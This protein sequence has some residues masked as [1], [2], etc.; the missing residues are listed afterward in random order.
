MKTI[1]ELFETPKDSPQYEANPYELH[2]LLGWKPW[3]PFPAAVW[4]SE[5]PTE[6]WDNQRHD[7]PRLRAVLDSLHVEYMKRKGET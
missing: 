3:Q 1:D 6:I 4:A 5:T 7:W 2:Q